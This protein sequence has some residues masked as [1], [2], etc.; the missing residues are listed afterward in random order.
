M[1]QIIEYNGVRLAELLYANTKSNS[2]FFYSD[3]NSP[4]QLGIMVH[5]SGFIEPAHRHPII[6]REKTATQQAFTVL[7]GKIFVDFFKENGELIKEVKL[8]KHDTILIIEGIHRI[9]V[10]RK[11]KCITLKQGPFIKNLDKIEATF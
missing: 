9:R 1:F 5:S 2:T 3:E 8:S 7:K 4:L 6:S 11:S 10:K